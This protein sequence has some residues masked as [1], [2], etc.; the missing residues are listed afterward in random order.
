MLGNPPFL[1]GQKLSGNYG[2]N[3]LEYLKY[4]YKPIGAVDLVTYFFRRIF[5]IIKLNGFQSL[6]STNTIAQGSAREGGLDVIFSNNGV[7]NHAIRSM[8]WPGQAA[9]EVSLITI[10]KGEWKNKFILDNKSVDRITP[11]LDDSE[12][13]GKP[14]PLKKQ[15]GKKFSRKHCSRKRIYITPR[16][17]FSFD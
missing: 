14:M 7:I 2:T 11:Y 12:V 1:G 10:H 13:M 9:V 15:L 6:I 17:S 5:D 3:F 16:R 4:T 8:K